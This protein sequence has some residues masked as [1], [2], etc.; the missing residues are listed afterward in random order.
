MFVIDLGGTC[1]TSVLSFHIQLN[2][3][4]I[5]RDNKGI[6]PGWLLDRITI[7]VDEKDEHYVFYCNRWIGSSDN[8]VDFT[9]GKQTFSVAD[10][11]L[12]WEGSGPHQYTCQ[13]RQNY[14]IT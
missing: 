7:D 3:V 11:E 2:S 9:P 10:R 5:S 12:G 14:F 13:R 6:K 1:L 4:R 8:A